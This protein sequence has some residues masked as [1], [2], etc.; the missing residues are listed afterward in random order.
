MEP[1][2]KRLSF[3]KFAN[4][5]DFLAASKED[6]KLELLSE[7]NSTYRT[8][9]SLFTLLLL[10]KLYEKIEGRLPL[11][12]EWHATLLVVLLL[13]MFLFSYRKQTSYITKRIQANA[14]PAHTSALSEPRVNHGITDRH[15]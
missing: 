14:T 8:L 9:C 7:V 3:V 12:R 10:V 11:L 2:L 15:D 4:Y 5:K 13:V 1:I 6:R